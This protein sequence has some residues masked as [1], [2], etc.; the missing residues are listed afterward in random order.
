MTKSTAL[1]RITQ[2]RSPAAA[3]KFYLLLLNWVNPK[4]SFLHADLF[5]SSFTILPP[6]YRPKSLHNLFA[7]NMLIRH[8]NSLCSLLEYT[9]SSSAIKGL[10]SSPIC[11][12][13]NYWRKH[14]FW[15]RFGQI[16]FERLLIFRKPCPV[17]WYIPVEGIQSIL[18]YRY[19]YFPPFRT[20]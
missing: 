8:T 1:P 7:N 10:C 11:N 18:L 3:T 20:H 12:I 4:S 15:A 14:R 19:G 6:P 2:L 13:D 17:H 5:I 16:L 9:L